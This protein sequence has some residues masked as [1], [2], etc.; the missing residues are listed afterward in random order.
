MLASAYERLARIF[1]KG[2]AV[3]ANIDLGSRSTYRCLIR[4][5][6][7]ESQRRSCCRQRI[8]GPSRA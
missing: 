3:V 7:K 8:E 5:G 2:E 6:S 4:N 1:S